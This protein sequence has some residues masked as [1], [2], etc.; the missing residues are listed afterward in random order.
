MKGE[1]ETLYTSESRSNN[2]S[3]TKRGYNGDKRRSHQGTAQLERAQKNDNNN[4]QGKRFEGICYNCGKRG[5]I[6][7]DCWFK[8]N[9]VESNVAASKK[10]MEDEWDA[11]VSHR[12]RRASTH[13]NDGRAYQL[14]G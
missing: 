1:E 12:R 9:S 6:S 3:S 10:K 11:D 8:K 2:K 4:S 5:H 14:R 13:G 7:R